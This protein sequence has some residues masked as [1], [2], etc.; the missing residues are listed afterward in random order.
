VTD[1]PPKTGESAVQLAPPPP[2]AKPE[3]ESFRTSVPEAGGTAR[4]TFLATTLGIAKKDRQVFV[5]YAYR[6]YP[7]PDYRK[8]YDRVAKNL[9]LKFVFADEKITDLHILQKIANMILESRFSI[10]DITGWNPNVTLELGLAYGFKE[11]AFI[12]FDPS[13]TPLEDVP[14][15]IRGLDRLQYSN[16]TELEEKLTQLAIQ[17]FPPLQL[18]D[19][20]APVRERIRSTLSQAPG[21]TA[22]EIAQSLGIQ[23]GYSRFV[24]ATMM[25]ENELVATG[26]TKGTRYRLP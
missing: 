1:N 19:P 21:L 15:D 9:G 16:F 14:A 23:V 11:Q 17:E 5:A 22:A 8:V 6:L 3:L 18:P 24:I 25:K 10:F 12:A 2:S 26:N 4:P 20:V 7:T 13:K